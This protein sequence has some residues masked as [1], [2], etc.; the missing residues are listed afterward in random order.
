MRNPHYPI[1]PR[2]PDYVKIEDYYLSEAQYLQR[3]ICAK[4]CAKFDAYNEA[5]GLP[6]PGGINGNMDRLG[7][8]FQLVEK[9]AQTAA[10][11]KSTLSETCGPAWGLVTV[12]DVRTIELQPQSWDLI[13]D[14]SGLDHVPPEDVPKV[15][16][17]YATWAMKGGLL[18]LV[19]WTSPKPRM[20]KP[21]TGDQWYFDAAIVD[22]ALAPAFSVIR[23]EPIWGLRDDVLM[24]W[25][26]ERK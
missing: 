5:Y 21:E 16:G 19:A 13:L 3:A 9:D 24:K 12:A 25:I 11:A 20:E 23:R 4:N 15:I 8:N 17:Q 22:A 2:N 1:P 18:F 10:L 6:R 7:C 14:L 26:C